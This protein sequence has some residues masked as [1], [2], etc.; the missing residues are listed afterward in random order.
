MTVP[1]A[2]ATT[3]RTPDPAAT[4][5]GRGAAVP[6]RLLLLRHGQSPLSVER[7]YSGRGNPALTA[8]GRRQAAAAAGSIATRFVGDDRGVHALV[9]SPLGRARETAAPVA[10]ALG[11][12]VAVEERFTETDF[13][14]WE[15]LTFGEAA[16]RDPEVHRAWLGDSAVA[17][18]GGESF[19]AVAARIRESLDGLLATYPGRTVVVVSH[20]T[21]IKTLLRIALD[22]GPGLL[23]RLHLDLA[24]LSIVE[25]WPDGGASV[26]LVNDTSHLR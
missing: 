12:D 23:Y 2:P 11:L 8:L 26:R 25:F 7:R 22:A 3:A 19:D 13:G 20:V 21:P 18:P 1:G 17:P 4:W 9:S 6:T 15:G 16:E 24:C 14:E 5:T 10:A